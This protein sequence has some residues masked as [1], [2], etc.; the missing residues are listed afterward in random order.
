VPTRFERR[1]RLFEVAATQGGYFTSA[2]ARAIGYDPRTL[3]HHVR[4]G[5]FERVSRGF[6]RLAEFPGQS[7]EDV[8][9]A[10]VKAGRERAV[11]SHETALALYDLS[12]VRPRKLHLTVARAYRPYKGQVRLAGVQ[13]H[14]TA[15]PYRLGEIVWR[16][17]VRITSPTRTIVDAAETGT[18]PS[19]IL[20]AVGRALDEGLLTADELRQTAEDRPK[21]V[22]RL[23]ERSIEEAGR[24]APVR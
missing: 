18:E 11:V 5:H 21:R 6:Y 12:P 8:I 4:S 19:V 24:R 3:W 13:I 15:R 22:R 2:Q 16:F 10:W 20:E 17:G 14:T 9:A 7:H 1:R 23:I